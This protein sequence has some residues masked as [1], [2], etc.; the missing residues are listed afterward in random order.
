MRII[1]IFNSRDFNGGDDYDYKCIMMMISVTNPGDGDDNLY[2]HHNKFTMITIT[3]SLQV[4]I[5]PFVPTYLSITKFGQYITI[6]CYLKS[7]RF[8]FSRYFYHRQKP[9]MKNLG[10]SSEKTY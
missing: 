10:K 9:H 3:T 1:W 6:M 7:G 8:K 4:F 5:S 2:N